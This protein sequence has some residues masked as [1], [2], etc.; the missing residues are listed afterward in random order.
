VAPE[1]ESSCSAEPVEIEP[2]TMG[3]E[4]AFRIVYECEG[5]A[6]GLIATGH[7]GRRYVLGVEGADLA[8]VEQGLDELLAG[9]EF[10]E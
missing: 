9:F 10:L 7:E 2:T 8:P 6:F 5:R 1:G 4:P 3:G